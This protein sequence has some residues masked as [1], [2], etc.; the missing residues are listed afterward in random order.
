[1]TSTSRM[2]IRT[3]SAQWTIPVIVTAAAVSLAGSLW[4]DRGVPTTSDW[5]IVGVLAAVAVVGAVIEWRIGPPDDESTPPWSVHTLWLLPAS[6][7][8]PPLAFLPL[9]ALSVALTFTRRA[10]SM[11]TRFVVSSITVMATAETHWMAQL[12][13]DVL[14]AGMIAI[15]LLYLTGMVVALAAAF[16][17][18]GPT[19][20][21]LWL[22]YRW[23]FVQWGCGL[24]G[25]LTTAAMSFSPLAGFTAL[26]PVLMAEF[27]LNWPELDRH[28]RIDSKTGL[29]N[30]R[31]WEDRSRDLISA[32]RLH[33]TPVAVAILDIDH[34]KAVNDTYGHL[35][36]DDVLEAVAATLRAQVDPG[37]LVGRF[38][39]EE[40]VIT[41]FGLSPERAG[42]VAERIRTAI[43]AQVHDARPR[44]AMGQS[45]YDA[46]LAAGTFSVTCTVGLASSSTHG[47]DLTAMLA[48]ADAALAEG[49][50]SGR[51]TVHHA[52]ARA[53]SRSPV[54]GRGH[55]GFPGEVPDALRVA[56]SKRSWTHVA[57]QQRATQRGRGRRR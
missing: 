3:G 47:F 45:P 11:A 48:G 32:A 25:L 42:A 6:L 10:H 21:A 29:P 16:V 20:T 33:D 18:T 46:D 1:M 26:A 44:R 22:D 43:G 14:L 7:L 41:L 4:A 52:A 57:N 8:A 49:K 51:D 13:D 39:G 15:V 54:G 19:G 31:H 55:G 5:S 17:F 38:G 34:F 24:A 56:T 23:S 35:V 9:L 37:D 28:A 2:P 30:A 50:A 27:T 40:F 36:G 12:F 53:G